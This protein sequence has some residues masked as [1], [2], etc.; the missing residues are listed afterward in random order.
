MTAD[1]Q[2]TALVVGLAVAL[3]AGITLSVLLLVAAWIDE[4]RRDALGRRGDGWRLVWV[5][6]EVRREMRP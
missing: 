2:Q 5:R 4:A 1:A 6:T 3:L